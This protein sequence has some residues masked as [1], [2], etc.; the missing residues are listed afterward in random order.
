MRKKASD[1]IVIKFILMKLACSD[2]KVLTKQGINVRVDEVKTG[3]LNIAISVIDKVLD[4][5][6]ER[7]NAPITLYVRNLDAGGSP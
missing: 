7:C 2:P 6:S 4:L 1:Y 3:V 5:I